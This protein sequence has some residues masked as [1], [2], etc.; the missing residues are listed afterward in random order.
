[1]LV[2]FNTFINVGVAGARSAGTALVPAINYDANGNYSIGDNFDRTTTQQ[3]THPNLQNN[4]KAV[5]GLLASDSI[6]YGT[7]KT[8]AW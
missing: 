7:H 3:A 4:G 2:P 8:E 5:Y 6:H 1:M